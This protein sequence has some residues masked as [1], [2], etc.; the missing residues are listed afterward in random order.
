MRAAL[1]E[2]MN[3]HASLREGEGQEGADGVERDE[4]VGNSTED[5]K[6]KTGENGEYGDSVCINEAA[7]SVGKNVRQIVVLGDGTAQAGKI[8][9]SSIG[10]QRQHQKD[11]G[12]GQVIENALAEDR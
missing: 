11:R 9:E 6:K 2:P 7:A 5:N 4:A 1:P 10:G 12:D 3:D 8:G